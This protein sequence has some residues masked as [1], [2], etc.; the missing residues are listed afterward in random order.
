MELN[1]ITENISQKKILITGNSG[2]KGTWLSHIFRLQGINTIGYSD[3][4][5]GEGRLGFNPGLVVPTTIGSILDTRKLQLCM[6]EHKPQIVIHLAAQSLVQKSYQNPRETFEVNAMGTYNVAEAAMRANSVET[7]LVV[8]SDK[9]YLPVSSRIFLAET[10]CLGGNDPYSASKAG[11][12]LAIQALRAINRETNRNLRILVAR[13]GNVIGGGDQAEH[14]LLPDII[15]SLLNQRNIQLRN[16]NQIRPWQ[17][18]LESLSGYLRFLNKSYETLEL[19]NELNF[20]P[21]RSDHIKVHE[22]ASKALYAWSGERYPFKQNDEKLAEESS[23][24]LLD[25]ELAKTTLSWSPKWDATQAI[26]ATIEWWKDFDGLQ[27]K[28]YCEKLFVKD[29]NKYFS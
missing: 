5:Q 21:D 29:I 23:Q 27:E 19:P 7:L 24:I 14:R 2:F 13:A 22:V 6:D 26:N 3:K 10:S 12:E 18:V 8:T 17:H 20:G 16:P 4:E 28:S 9:V 25:S 11:S 1:K 15:E